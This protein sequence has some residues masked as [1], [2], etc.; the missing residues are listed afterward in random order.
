VPKAST[1]RE[2][3]P[4][5]WSRGVIKSSGSHRAAFVAK[6][7]FPGLSAG[8][9]ILAASNDD[10][11]DA[12]I[13]ALAMDKHRSVLATLPPVADRVSRLEG[14]IWMSPDS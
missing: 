8:M 5:A 12:A 13:S 1:I 6:P 4:R 2:I 11:F 9:R 3:Y 14:L 7:R 10:A